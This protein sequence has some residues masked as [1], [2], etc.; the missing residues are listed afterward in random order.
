MAAGGKTYGLYRSW[1]AKKSMGCKCD[2]L[3]TGHDCGARVCPRGDDPLT[4][5]VD[6]TQLTTTSLQ[7]DEVQN[8]TVQ[9]QGLYG[10]NGGE[11]AFTFTD[12]LI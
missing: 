4:R 3:Y 11:V 12:V 2:P 1:D 7:L 8:V 5:D 10:I 6:V 9:A